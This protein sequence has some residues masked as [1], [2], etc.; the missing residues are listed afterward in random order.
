MTD[1]LIGQYR[2]LDQHAKEPRWVAWRNERRGYKLTKV[3]YC[4]PDKKAKADDPATW[5]CRAEAERVAAKIVNGL[6]GGVGYELGDLGNDLYIGGIDL[7]SCLNNGEATD[8]AAAIMASAPTYGEQSPSGTG[9]KLFFYLAAEDVRPF[10]DLIAVLPTQWGCRRDVPGENACDHGPAVEIYLSHRYFAVTE[11]RWPD[12]PEQIT[13]LEWEALQR[14]ATLIPPSKS[15]DNSRS[16]AAFRKGAA[17]RRAGKTFEEMV[18]ALRS[19]PETAAWVREK[20]EAAGGRELRR[21]WEKAALPINEAAEGTV[22]L[23][24][25]YAYMPMHNYVYVPSREPWPA[26]SVNARIPPVAIVNA[27]GQPVLNEQGKPKAIPASLWLDQNRPVEQMSWAPGESAVIANRLISHGGWIEHQGAHCLNLYRPPTNKLGDPDRAQRWVEHV[28]NVFADDAE[29]VINWLAQ[30]V[31]RPQ[32]KINHALVLGGKMGIGKDTMLE[33]A[34]IAVGP[35]NFREIF[36]QQL[37]G[38]FNGFVKSVIL[39][40][41]EARDLGDVNRYQFYDHLKAYTAAPPDV[42][43]CDEKNLREHSVFNCCGVIITTNHKTDGIYLPEDDR[44]HY[45]AWSDRDKADFSE[46]YWSELYDWY[47]HGGIEHVCALL[48]TVDISRFNPK[49]PP[50]RTQAFW[51]I[52]D[53]SRAPEDAELE[54]A[55]D[56]L[57]KPD[58]VTVSKVAVFAS[59]SFREWLL[60]RKNSRRI[61]HRFEACGYVAVRNGD[62]KNGL[63]VVEGK[64]QVIYGKDSLTPSD[65]LLAALRASG[66]RQ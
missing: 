33:P 26:P 53:A 9:L 22:S 39:R 31:Q 52:V 20:G 65:R 44:R 61:P 3:P 42:L 47:D 11:Q 19:D 51:E 37:I 10:L 66:A 32:V 63:W 34:K 30:R 36:P 17:L 43:L 38:R 49:A 1:S 24:D 14:L 2:A 13:V 40:I 21:I 45:V 54:D 46:T 15:G 16:A 48:S 5:L 8:W 29:H 18:A 28:Q 4:A 56:R 50:P 12:L 55:L 62:R 58:I 60:D 41:S 7:D 35:W 23:D 6:G 57:Q 25:F 64:R 27:S 59:D